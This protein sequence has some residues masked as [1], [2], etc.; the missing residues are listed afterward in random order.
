MGDLDCRA[1]EERLPWLTNG[2]L[3]SEERHAVKAHLAGCAGCRAALAATREAAALFALHPPAE[4]IADYAL[5]L[6][7]EGMPREQVEA[8]LGHCAACREEVALVEAEERGGGTPARP[9]RPSPARRPAA[10]GVLA[11]AAMLVA[12]LGLALWLA[13]REGAP[14][15]GGRVALVELVPESA[16]RRGGDPGGARV[17]AG[18]PS[19]LLLLTDRAER[20]EEVRARLVDP[21]GG[22]TIW[23]AEG[24]LAPADGV[25]ALLVPAR[26]LP[27]GELVVELE[28]ARGGEWTAIERY[29]LVVAP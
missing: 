8:H 10:R 9:D 15:V 12:S 24:L 26:A 13:T 4:T 2:S 25:Y 23:R 21:E 19:T 1:I 22:R 29:A 7:V 17:Q 5:G 16:R 18:M 6:V 11:L 27:R 20:F 3:S 14:P 28:G